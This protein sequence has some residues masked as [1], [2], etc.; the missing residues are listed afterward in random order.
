MRLYYL[1][2]RVFHHDEAAVGYFTYKLFNDSVYSYDPSFHGPF[3]YYATS[4]MYRLIGDSDYSSRLLPA[5]LG[6][7]H[8]LFFFLFF[9]RACRSCLRFFLRRSRSAAL[10]FEAMGSGE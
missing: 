2:E 10:S 1:D 7:H 3:M 8:F 6:A 9:L 4:E 5:L